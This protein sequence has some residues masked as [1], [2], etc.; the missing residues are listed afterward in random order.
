[1]NDSLQEASCREFPLGETLNADIGGYMRVWAMRKLL[2]PPYAIEASKQSCGC[3]GLEGIV[4]VEGIPLSSTLAA[5]MFLDPF[6]VG[7]SVRTGPG[8]IGA[9]VRAWLT[10]R[11][12]MPPA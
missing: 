1:M 10:A 11:R 7:I 5:A 9:R 2:S 6:R 8:P 12:V 3:Q 4:R